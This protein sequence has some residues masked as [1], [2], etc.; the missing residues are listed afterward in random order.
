MPLCFTSCGKEVKQGSEGVLSVQSKEATPLYLS[1]EIGFE[2]DLRA[3]EFKLESVNGKSIPRPQ[4]KDKQEVEVHTIIWGANGHKEAKTLKWK[5]DALTKKLVLKGTFDQIYFT[6]QDKLYLSALLA[7]N[8]Q[9]A[10]TRVSFA[11]TRELHGV[12]VGGDLMG[13]LNVPYAL[14]W[15]ALSI[16]TKKVANSGASQAHAFVTKD[17]QAKFKPLGAMIAYKLGNQLKSGNYTFLPKSMM[18]TSNVWGDK[19]TFELNPTGTP[20]AGDFP[21]WKKAPAHVMTYTFASGHSPEVISKG[22]VDEK[23]YFAWVMPNEDASD[24][25]RVT[26]SIVVKGDC[27]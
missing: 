12:K 19:G 18:V 3:I 22:S 5:Y 2:D 10:D 13:E 7:P 9:L 8:T 11:G 26:T 17:V 4:F 20:K 15:T 23:I 16:E 25:E 1:A 24:V 6:S 14:A 27:S 21:K